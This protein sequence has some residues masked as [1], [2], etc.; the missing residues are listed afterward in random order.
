MILDF[1][2]H[3]YE[4]NEVTFAKELKLIFNAVCQVLT[5]DIFGLRVLFCIDIIRLT[6]SFFFV[7]KKKLNNKYTKL[8]QEQ[9]EWHERLEDRQMN[10]ENEMREFVDRKC[11]LERIKYAT[12][13]SSTGKLGKKK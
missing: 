6:S 7:L 8:K 2:L 12:L 11:T 13:S 10:L 3:F 5:G 9:Q 4:K 1:L